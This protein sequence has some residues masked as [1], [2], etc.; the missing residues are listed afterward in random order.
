MSPQW[1]D[2]HKNKIAS[3]GS[4]TM[5]MIMTDLVL[6]HYNLMH[7]TSTSTPQYC[8]W[9]Q[10]STVKRK[11][12]QM[13][14]YVFH[15]MKKYT[16]LHRLSK[17]SRIVCWWVLL[18]R[19]VAGQLSYLCNG[20]WVWFGHS[21]DVQLGVALLLNLRD[22][23]LE[24]GTTAHGKKDLGGDAIGD[25]LQ[26]LLHKGLALENGPNKIADFTDFQSSAHLEVGHMKKASQLSQL[27]QFFFSIFS[28]I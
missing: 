8:T 13:L 1:E 2:T 19:K 26:A 3:W 23:P 17:A 20:F 28:P 24:R 10:F 18:V 5:Y 4:G 14:I 22:H 16:I 11:C 25:A 15:C 6:R 27:Y 9:Q 7:F 21:A 12:P